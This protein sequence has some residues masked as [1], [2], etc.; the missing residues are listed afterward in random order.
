MKKICSICSLV[1]L[2][3][4][5]NFVQ[6]SETETFTTTND[7]NFLHISNTAGTITVAADESADETSEVT[8]TVEKQAAGLTKAAA[9]TFLDQIEVVVE[10]DGDSY[11]VTVNTPWDD[12]SGPPFAAGGA[13]I[14]FSS[15][16]EKQVTIDTEAGLVN[17]EHITGGYITATAG[18]V[19]VQ[20]AEGDLTVLSE[21]GAVEIESFSGDRFDLE[22]S[23]GSISIDVMGSGAVN[24]AAKT[25]TGAIDIG[26]SQNL[27]CIVDLTTEVGGISVS[28]IED[29]EQTDDVTGSTATF[30]LGAGDGRISAE[31]TVG[32]IEAEVK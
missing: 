20:Q 12:G 30:T 6:E 24:G 22:A 29:Y 26:L 16:S 9:R 15:M 7:F 32:E 2:L 25:A 18:S 8:L 5:C 31:T 10:R 17:C 11:T 27:S 3:S 28:G 14:S 21:A 4:A 23:A 1:L 19:S 13:A